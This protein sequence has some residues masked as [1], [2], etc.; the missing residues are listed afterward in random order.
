MTKDEVL[1]FIDNKSRIIIR[2]G[3]QLS[4]IDVK[5]QPFD[6]F[7]IGALNRT[8]NLNKAFT[9]LSREK[10][11]I[12]AA[13]LIRINLDSLLR[14]YAGRISEYDLNTFALKVMG[15]H[16]I[17]RMKAYNGKEKLNDTYLVNQISQIEDME[18]VKNIYE[19]GNAFVH[20]SDE[21]IS[22]SRIIINQEE[23][24]IGLSIGFHDSFISDNVKL[25]ATMWMDRIVDSIIIQAQ[26]WMYEKCKIVGFDYEKLNDIN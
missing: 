5:L 23:R 16:H 8:A 21:I 25:G 19:S 7:L 24:K 2:L 9:S 14:L 17:K 22:A 11:F 26:L 10:N 6:L 20:F 15:G 12:A 3:K 18:W 13:A 1:D 4:A